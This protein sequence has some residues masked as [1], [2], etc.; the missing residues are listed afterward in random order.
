ME[1]A[2]AKQ[3]NTSLISAVPIEDVR[4]IICAYYTVTQ[5][6]LRRRTVLSAADES[7]VSQIRLD[8][9]SVMQ[10]SMQLD[11]RSKPRLWTHYVHLESLRPGHHLN[12]GVID[13]FLRKIEERSMKCAADV[14]CVPGTL[15]RIAVLCCDFAMSAEVHNIISERLA[16]PSAF[17]WLGW[18]TARTSV[19]TTF[20]LDLIMFPV[21]F[22]TFY[23]LGVINCRKRCV[24][25]YHSAAQNAD[26]SVIRIVNMRCSLVAS[27]MHREGRGYAPCTEYDVPWEVEIHYPGEEMAFAI[28]AN[29]ESGVYICNY[30]DSLALGLVPDFERVDFPGFRRR[31]IRDL[32]A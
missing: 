27:Y 25:V 11:H 31:M 2:G 29:N 13:V 32:L 3:A 8:T 16:L 17:D 10:P 9:S 18:C 20:C 12:Q 19:L 21:H 23:A 7:F 1:S 6:E 26:L 28:G 22:S 24:Q 30:A 14:D 5:D 4:M 15:P